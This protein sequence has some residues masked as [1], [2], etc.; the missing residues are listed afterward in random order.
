[1]GAEAISSAEVTTWVSVGRC[2]GRL[3]GGSIYFCSFNA[4]SCFWIGI[5]QAA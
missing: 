5:P 1:M 3:L 2:R 4:K